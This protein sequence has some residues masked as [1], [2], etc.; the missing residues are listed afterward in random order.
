ML[1]KHYVANVIEVKEE[2]SFVVGTVI[3][4]CFFL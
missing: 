1:R 4:K 2:K 3:N